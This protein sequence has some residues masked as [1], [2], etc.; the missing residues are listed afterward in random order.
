MNSS[1]I[2][3]FY[4]QNGSGKTAMV[5]AFALLKSLLDSK[6]LPDKTEY[7]L[8]SDQESIELFFDFLIKNKFGEYMVR[9]ESKLELDKERLTAVV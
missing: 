1:D 7:L 8:K 5:E 2:I 9:Y 4:G 3:G 6:E